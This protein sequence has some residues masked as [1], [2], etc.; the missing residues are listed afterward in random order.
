MWKFRISKFLC[1]PF[2]V[3]YK[4]YLFFNIARVQQ[5]GRLLF[6]ERAFMMCYVYIE[7]LLLAVAKQILSLTLINL[8]LQLANII[9]ATY[10][11]L[12][13]EMH[14]AEYGATAM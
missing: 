3:L 5:D 10:P 11:N 6:R 8:N 13:C 2:F 12:W 14:F 1:F 7:V 9:L 4:I